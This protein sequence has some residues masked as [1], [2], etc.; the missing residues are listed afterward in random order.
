MRDYEYLFLK[1]IKMSGIIKKDSVSTFSSPDWALNKK[2]LELY[3][4]Y[5][6]GE[7]AILIS[8]P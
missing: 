1:V 8:K 2:L 7:R 5:F 6:Q 4:F 3:D